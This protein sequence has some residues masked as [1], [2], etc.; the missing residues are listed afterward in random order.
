MR[1]SGPLDRPQRAFDA[2]ELSAYVAQRVGKEL[3]RKAAPG[4]NIPGITAPTDGNPGKA[5]EPEKL[6]RGLLDS[7]RR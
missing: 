5:P 7:L 2:S 3:L 1:L 4:L 6:I